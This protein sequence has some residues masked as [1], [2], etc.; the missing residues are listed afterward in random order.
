[1]GTLADER[2]VAA[3]ILEH[4]AA[5]TTDLADAVWHEPVA[6]YRS[7]ERFDA[8]RALL[9]R[10]PV[11]FC[12]SAALGDAGSYVARDAAGVPIVAVRDRD[13][14]VRAF[15]NACRHRGTQLVEGSGCANAFVCGYHGWTYRLDGALAHVPHEHGFPG[16]DKQTRGLVSVHAVER[17]GLVFVNQDAPTPPGDELAELDGLIGPEQRL[18]AAAEQEHPTNWKVLVETFLE[19]LHIRFAHGRTFYPLQYDNLNLV[20]TFGEHSRV[21]FPYRNVEKLATVP[22]AERTLDARVTFVYHLFPNVII[23]TFPGR[24]L[25]FVIEPR[26]VDRTAIVTY[27][28]SDRP[29]GDGE[30]RQRAGQALVLDGGAEDFAL[31][32][33]VQRGLASGA[34][35]HLE[36]GLFEGALGHF[37]R[38]LDAALADHT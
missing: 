3:R 20:E 11:P 31:A 7:V 30:E 32:R 35:E 19:G 29:P 22:T 27:A 2:T 38:N 36:L 16:L 14:R 24:I 15:R 6:N 33:A 26:E 25:M 13:G 1:M 5:G 10:R 21:T 23:A 4:V 37:H 12:P 8:E 17:H 9:R 28:L 18:I 34:N